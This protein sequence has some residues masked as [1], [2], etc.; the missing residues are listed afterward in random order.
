MTLI[1]GSSADLLPLLFSLLLA[2]FSYLRIV[3]VLVARYTVYKRTTDDS[4]FPL[5]GRCNGKDSPVQSEV[6]TG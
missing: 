1:P 4:S 2:T 3:P 5:L 6:E